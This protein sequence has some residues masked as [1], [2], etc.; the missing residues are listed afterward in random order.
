M[1]TLG[2]IIEITF[3]TCSQQRFGFG[4]F[5]FQSGTIQEQAG[6]LTTRDL[7]AN[8]QI[9][10]KE[11]LESSSN[12]GKFAFSCSYSFQL[13]NL[14]T[15]GLEI[16]LS[17]EVL[18]IVFLYIVQSKINNSVS[19]G[20][21]RTSKKFNFIV[22]NYFLLEFVRQ[23]LALFVHYFYRLGSVLSDRCSW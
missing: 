23:A 19:H 14:L 13:E 5:T 1:I 7:Q 18:H 4:V 15:I 21:T 22:L 17:Q 9:S 20:C 12:F 8:I 10:F 11:L 2:F 6:I 3:F 16:L